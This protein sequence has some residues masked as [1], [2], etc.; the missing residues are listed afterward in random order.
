MRKKGLIAMAALGLAAVSLTALMHRAPAEEKNKLTAAQ[1]LKKCDDFHFFMEDMEIHIDVT[2]IAGMGK[3]DRHKMIML[4]KGKEKRLMRWL[5]PKDIADFS[6]LNKDENTMY[7]FEPSLGKVRRIASHAKKQTFLG[8]DYTKSEASIF[9]LENAYDPKSIGEDDGNYKLYLTQKKDKDLA[10]PILKVFVSKKDFHAAQIQYCDEK[11]KK[12][13]TEMRSGVKAWDGHLYG[14]GSEMV[15]HTKQ[16][17]TI[18][19]YTK[20]K[21][22]QGLDDDLFTKRN[23]VREE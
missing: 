16:H 2:V 10:W 7:V 13:K 5:E 22:N 1:I 11:D 21:F 20:V 6:I 15:D 12:H 19:E 17:T 18:Y 8:Y 3:K 14:S 23:L 9:R 4:Q